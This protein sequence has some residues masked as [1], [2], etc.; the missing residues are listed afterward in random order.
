MRYLELSINQ[1]LASKGKDKAGLAN[2]HFKL[3]GLLTL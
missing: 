1:A 3:Y 2:R